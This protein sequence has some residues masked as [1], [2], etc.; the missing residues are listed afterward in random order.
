MI[1]K[2]LYKPESGEVIQA[3]E[4][5][6]WTEKG[7][8]KPVIDI[9]DEQWN[10]AQDKKNMVVDGQ[11]VSEVEQPQLGQ[12][13]LGYIAKLNTLYPNL[14]LLATDTIEDAKIKMITAEV[15]YE[16]SATLITF[17]DKGW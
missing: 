2:L 8:P 11:L 3:L 12:L 15:T 16:E 17:Y 9:T 6:D 14:N 5:W 13:T 4:E 10:N 1:I 7:C